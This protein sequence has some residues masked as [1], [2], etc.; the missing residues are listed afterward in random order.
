MSDTNPTSI[1]DL[2]PKQKLS[3]TVK[4]VELGGAIVDVGLEHDG[5]LLPSKVADTYLHLAQQ[6]RSSWTHEIDMR[7]FSDRPW[8]NH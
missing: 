4:K 1:N 5:L 7:S 3:G 6:H 2:E 8:W